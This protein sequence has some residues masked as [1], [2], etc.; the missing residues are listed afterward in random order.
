MPR[1]NTPAGWITLGLHENLHETMLIALE[2]MVNFIGAQ[3]GLSRLDSLAM[4]SLIVDFRIML[5]EHQS[6]SLM[7][8][9]KRSMQK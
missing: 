4:A 1:A 8:F 9:L 7:R 3:Y 2:A 6:F 5:D